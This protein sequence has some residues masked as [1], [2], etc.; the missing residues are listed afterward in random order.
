MIGMISISR[1]EAN[2]DEISPA[3]SPIDPPFDRATETR[4]ERAERRRR[5]RGSVTGLP[6]YSEDPEDAE[7]VLL[8]HRPTNDAHFLVL[9]PS[10][11]SSDS[12]FTLNSTTDHDSSY[13]PPLTRDRSGSESAF[14]GN[15]ILPLHSI[16]TSSP[17]P[18][19]LSS[20]DLQRPPN[21][22]S[23][24]TVGRSRASTMRSIFSRSEAVQ[25][26]SPYSSEMAGQGSRS[27]SSLS[28]SSPL[29]HTLGQS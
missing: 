17:S 3:S 6:K 26:S 2:D 10:L 9:M 22:A 13:T 1:E 18:S 14:Y 25:N 8:K 28:I 4:E 23:S 11:P 20:V 27:V 5:R 15:T 12:T 19:R 24:P 7:M 29:S 16:V 21:I